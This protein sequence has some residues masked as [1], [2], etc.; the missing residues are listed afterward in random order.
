MSI[1]QLIIVLAL[2][3]FLLF[4]VTTWIPMPP[5]YRQLFIG[6]VCL[7]VLLYVLQVFGVFS[8]MHS[9]RIG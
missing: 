7:C 4:A 8:G 1:I 3:G 5:P 9:A 2:V 6:I